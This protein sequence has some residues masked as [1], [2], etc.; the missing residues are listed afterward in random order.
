MSQTQT[1]RC[2]GQKRRRERERRERCVL[3]HSGQ[4][5]DLRDPDPACVTLDD[6]A[7]AL[8]VCRRFAGAGI[9]VAEH[10]V[11]VTRRLREQ[12]H[13]PD[14]QLAGLLHD[15]AEA[16]TGD[17]IAPFKALIRGHRTLEAR[18]DEAILHALGHAGLDLHNPTVKQA[19]RWAIPQEAGMV[20]LGAKGARRAFLREYERLI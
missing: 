19:D 8:A 6:I 12:G 14:V 18:I 16:Y 11:I 2:A 1:N 10:S 7:R 5:V 3:T 20:G 4:R 15:A 13:P 17:V 9:S